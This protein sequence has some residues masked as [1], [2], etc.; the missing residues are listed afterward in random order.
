MGALWLV[1]GS[2]NLEHNEWVVE[3]IHQGVEF[4]LEFPVPASVSSMCVG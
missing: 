3:S 1:K 4:G 2:L